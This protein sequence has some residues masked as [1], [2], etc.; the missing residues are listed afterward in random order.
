VASLN[1]SDLARD[2]RIEAVAADVKGSELRFECVARLRDEITT[3]SG[4]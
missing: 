1:L 2:G 3:S 4:R